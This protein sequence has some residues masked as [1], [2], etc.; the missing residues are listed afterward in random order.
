[1]TTIDKTYNIVI[2]VIFEHNCQKELLKGVVGGDRG[3]CIVEGLNRILL[4]GLIVELRAGGKESKD[5]LS[6]GTVYISLSTST[7]MFW[8]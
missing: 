4:N 5:R 1:M 7:R 6:Q 3:D 8:L 2:M